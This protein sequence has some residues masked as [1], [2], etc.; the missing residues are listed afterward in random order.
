MSRTFSFDLE[1]DEL[2]RRLGEGFPEGSIV[3]IEGENGAGKSTIVERLAYGFLVNGYTVTF[4]STQLTTKGFIHQMYS[5]DYPIGIHLLKDELLFIPV[6]P[7]IKSAKS[8][9][10]FIERLINAEKL[11]EKDIIIID[12]LSE[13]VK[14]SINAEKTIEL[15]SFFK[16]ITGMGK[17]VINTI[18]P[19]DLDPDVVSLFRSSADIYM[20]LKSRIIAGEVKRSIHVNK[21]TGATGFVGGV[22]GFR[23]EPGAG[24]VIE[25]ASVA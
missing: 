20:T 18:D 2:N 17:I 25:I 9:S 10:D 24:L 23:I 7:L 11:Y 12:K 19:V 1:R 5:L 16:K 15:I 13:L 3:L 4:I 22:I 6:V 14:Y 8:R 21:F